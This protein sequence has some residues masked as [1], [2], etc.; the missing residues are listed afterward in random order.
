MSQQFPDK[1]PEK[2]SIDVIER[3]EQFFADVGFSNGR[4]SLGPTASRDEIYS[5]IFGFISDLRLVAELER[6]RKER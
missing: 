4:H 1:A 2:V 6:K 5:L 3:N